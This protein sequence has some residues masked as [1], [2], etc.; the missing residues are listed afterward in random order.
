[1]SVLARPV[2]TQRVVRPSLGLASLGVTAL[3][4]A[5]VST[6][7]L[8]PSFASDHHGHGSTA[9]AAHVDD[10]HA[11]NDHGELAVGDH[12]PDDL[13]AHAGGD[14]HDADDHDGHTGHT[15]EADGTSACEQSGYANEGNAGHGHRGPAPYT[16]L[17]PEEREVFA[18]QVRQANEVVETY[19]T[20]ADAE[21]AGYRGITPY[22]PCIAAHY[23]NNELLV[24]GEFDPG[25]PEILLYDGT[26]PDSRIVGLSYLQFS[27]DEP[28]GFAGSNDPWHVHEYLC[29]GAGGVVGDESTSEEDCEARGGNLV[30]LGNLW[31]MHMW[32]VSGWDSRWGLFSSEHPDLGGRI[33]DING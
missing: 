27:D 16:P 7:A 31:M 18:E 23:I 20:V 24:N 2:I 14:H 9:D 26:D 11:H 1:V 4:I 15:I 33:G 10:D 32:N 5:V 19:P 30:D 13:T 8:S 22:V 12:P 28:D 25:A 17:T 29:L 6:M 3:A 21:A